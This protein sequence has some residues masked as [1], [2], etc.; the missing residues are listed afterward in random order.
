M[1][2][3]SSHNYWISEDDWQVINPKVSLRRALYKEQRRICDLGH[4]VRLLLTVDGSSSI[5]ETGMEVEFIITSELP[6][7]K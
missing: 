5:E 2:R 4:R 3:E 7:I 6:L 1:S